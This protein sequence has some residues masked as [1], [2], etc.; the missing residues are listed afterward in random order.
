MITF[1]QF[2]ESSGKIFYHG[3]MDYLP[4]GTILTPR[5]EYEKHWQ[6]TDFYKPLEMYRPPH[7]LAHKDS[8]FMCDNID[9]IDLAGGGTEYVFTVQPIGK[10]EK[11]DLNWSSEISAL[12]G[13]G[14]H[15]TDPEVKEA[16]A[17]ERDLQQ[18]SRAVQDEASRPNCKIQTV[19]RTR[20]HTLC[21]SGSVG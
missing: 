20:G 3:S 13:D 1:R 16:A 6:N 8:V 12:V 5:N 7:M 10:I 14:K 2:L 15:I 9:D 17:D 21:R 11:H 19:K 18:Y 4:A